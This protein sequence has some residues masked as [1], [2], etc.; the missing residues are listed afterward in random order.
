MT[1][2]N[3]FPGM[4]TPEEGLA[5]TTIMLLR[6]AIGSLRSNLANQELTTRE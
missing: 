1:G 4:K 3:F 6:T 2:D 5:R